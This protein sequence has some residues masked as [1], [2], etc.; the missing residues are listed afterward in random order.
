MIKTRD[1]LAQVL[2][3]SDYKGDQEQIIQKFLDL[4]SA[5]VL[6]ELIGIKPENLQKEI[7]DSLQGVK[8]NDEV[9]AILSQYFDEKLISAAY[10]KSS[11]ELFTA[12]IQDLLSTLSSEKEKVLQDYLQ[13]L[14]K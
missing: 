13:S 1:I 3:I 11:E 10:S 5:N 12:I 2:I 14:S 6:N 4:T 9:I 8:T 7:V